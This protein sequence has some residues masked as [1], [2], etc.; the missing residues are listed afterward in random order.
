MRRF[1]AVAL[2]AGTLMAGMAAVSA[3]AQADSVKLTD[4]AA[5]SAASTAAAPT[6]SAAARGWKAINTY[7]YIDAWGTYT[8][9]GGKTY[10]KA[11]LRDTKA[12]YYTA[13]VRFLFQ[14]GKRAYW[15]RHHIVGVRPN[16]SRYAFDGKGTITIRTSSSYSS[17]LWV[18]EC[19]RSTKNGK[20]YYGKG[21]KLF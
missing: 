14:E 12:N 21:K 18:Q 2:S 1:A 13:C 5:A 6:A 19:G 20:F 16:G 15:S 4:S 8:R 7:R 11:Y 9:S 3:P 10:V 17:H